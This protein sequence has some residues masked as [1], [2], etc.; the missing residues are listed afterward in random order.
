M[1]TN[2]QNDCEEKENGTSAS[3]NNENC[4]FE[5]ASKG[6]MKSCGEKNG[7]K[8]EK[9]EA[10]CWQRTFFAEQPAPCPLIVYLSL[11]ISSA[12]SQLYVASMVKI[13]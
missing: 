7:R 8:G 13:C 10:R 6:L 11:C 9:T 5:K 12:F 1:R 4:K 2:C 3:S